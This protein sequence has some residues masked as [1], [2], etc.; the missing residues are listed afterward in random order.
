MR[1]GVY[2]KAVANGEAVLVVG[3]NTNNGGTPTMA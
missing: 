1:E 3:E 2:R